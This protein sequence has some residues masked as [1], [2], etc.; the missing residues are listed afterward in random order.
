MSWD[1][2]GPLPKSRSYNTI[3][4]MVDVKT[5]AIKLEPADVT[6]MARGI[7]MVMRD[8]VFREEGLPA[9]VISDRGP[10]I[11]SRFMKELYSLLGIE[12]NLST[13]YHPQMDGKT[14]RMNWEVE[15]YLQMF[16]NFQQDDWVDWLPLAEFAYNNVINES[17]G[18]TPFYLN[19]GRHP[20]TLPTD[21]TS[22]EGTVAEEFLCNIQN[23]TRVAE[24]SLQKTK[25]AMK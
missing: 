15:K 12:G 25:E 5:K 21:P 9:K 7:A 17:T 1:M 14:E 10:Q 22:R 6:I 4:T 23:A 13:A 18:Q 24:E 19:K 8:R 3:V 16:T 11:V 20:R 2:I